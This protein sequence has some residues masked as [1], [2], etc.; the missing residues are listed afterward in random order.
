MTE[1][2][3]I[4][5]LINQNQTC[6]GLIPNKQLAQSFAD[7]LYQFMFGCGRSVLNTKP[8]LHELYQHLKGQLTNLLN[9]LN[10]DEDKKE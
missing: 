4:S 5:I 6:E 8:N 10:V 3:F 2:Q 7:G 1:D 9:E